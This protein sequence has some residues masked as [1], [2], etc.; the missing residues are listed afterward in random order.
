MRYSS[1][2]TDKRTDRQTD[3]HADTLSVEVVIAATRWRVNLLEVAGGEDRFELDSETGVVRTKGSE[4]FPY[5]KEYEIGVSARDVSVNTLQ[6]S[7]THSVKIFVGERD[8]QFFETQY[9]ASVPETEVA[10]FQYVGA[11]AETFR[12]KINNFSETNKAN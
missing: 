2:Q 12:R 11:C 8:P 3:R 6:R 4:S 1:G 9:V 5:G 7:P 10:Q